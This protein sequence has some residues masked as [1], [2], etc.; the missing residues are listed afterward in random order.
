MKRSYLTVILF[1]G[2][3]PTWQQ[4]LGQPAFKD[5]GRVDRADFRQAVAEKYPDAPAVILFDLG[6]VS[7]SSETGKVRATY[8]FFRRIL[9]LKEEGLKWAQV[10]IPFKRRE[11]EVKGIKG[12]TYFLNEAGEV[13][14][15]RLD[16]R[17]VDDVSIDDDYYQKVFPLP[18]ARVG[19]IIEYSYFLSSYD[20]QSLQTWAFQY[21]IPNVY[22]DFKAHIP[23]LIDYSIAYQ[24]NLGNLQQERYR[25]RQD[26][27]VS[28]DL[29]DRDFMSTYGARRR[30]MDGNTFRFFMEDIPPVANEPFTTIP[31]DNRARVDFQLAK[32]HLPGRNDVVTWRDLNSGLL[33]DQDFGRVLEDRMVIEKAEEIAGNLRKD[34]RQ[35][36]EIFEFV[37]NNI[38]WDGRYDIYT[39]KDL[40]ET[41]TNGYG[42]SADINMLL[43]D[44]LQSI[45][46]LSYPML[47]STRDH[48]KVEVFKPDLRQ[49]NH[50]IVYAKVRN[51]T[52]YL[53]A[54]SRGTPFN[55]LPR[56]DL[57]DVGFLVDKRNWGWIDIMPEYEIVRNTY[58]RFKLEP[59]GTLQGDLEVIFKEYSA[60]IERGRLATFDRQSEAYI[61]EQFLEGLENTRIY[62]FRIENAQSDKDVP[63][64]VSCQLET[65][66][67]VQKAND[68]LFIRPLFTKSILENPFEAEV[69]ETPIDLPCPIR[70]Y[71]L[72]GLVIPDGYTIEQTPHPIRVLLPNDAGSFTFNV[73]QDN[74][75]IHVSSTI[76]IEKTRYTPQE[77]LEIKTFFE[78]IIRKHQEDI[79]LK[80]KD[81]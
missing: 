55:M 10:N 14:E 72:L 8:Q 80:K 49:F 74:N 73:L 44:M 13:E 11:E 79:I 16:K 18:G 57:N 53:D 48:G 4:G 43:L 68:F 36:E 17:V 71:Y 52:F 56:K 47:I 64:H 61:R 31:E 35:V 33:R 50:V 5:Q 62:N 63:I 41:L 58:T 20:I 22:S 42:N 65:D 25:F 34:S 60:A 40:G 29:L 37:R 28:Q 77:Y 66:D 81:A 70:E 67:Y 38:K 51:E 9:I 75:I 7:F 69:R 39:T 6:E 23:H 45:G 2:L 15:L 59:D 12:A 78:Y 27:M 1:L 26:E 46:V 19:A 54:L 32:L 30:N 24:G 76:F 21:E 3:L